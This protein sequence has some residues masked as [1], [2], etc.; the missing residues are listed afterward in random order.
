[1][2]HTIGDTTLGRLAL[3]AAERRDHY[4]VLVSWLTGGIVHIHGGCKTLWLLFRS[5]DHRKEIGNSY[6]GW[7]ILGRL[8]RRIFPFA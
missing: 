6:D 7:Q 4:F 5:G 1:M 8:D 3:I 2:N